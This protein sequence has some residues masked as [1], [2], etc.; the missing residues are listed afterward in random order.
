MLFI[1]AVALFIFSLYFSLGPLRSFEEL[2][3]SEGATRWMAAGM[4]ISLLIILTAGNFFFFDFPWMPFLL[5]VL[6]GSVM[7][8]WVL[9]I[10]PAAWRWQMA[11]ATYP[12]LEEKWL[13]GLQDKIN[14]RTR[15]REREN[16]R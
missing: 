7:V 8:S 15:K 5:V 12:V 6:F 4:F 13:N 10:N 14:A 16:E 3:N 9:K 2:K 1:P 11:A